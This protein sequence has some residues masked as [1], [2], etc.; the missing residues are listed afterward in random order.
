M[1]L[2]P[3]R[4]AA[5]MLLISATFVAGYNVT[6]RAQSNSR[7]AA[8]GAFQERLT[9]LDQHLQT[10]EQRFGAAA[11]QIESSSRIT[12][13]DM[14]ASA[15]DQ[16]MEAYTEALK[17]ATEDALADAER[18]AKSQGR[19]GNAQKL[20]LLETLVKTHERRT[21]ALRT[22]SEKVYAQVKAGTIVLDRPVLDAL[23]PAER[24][25][26]GNFLTASARKRYPADLVPGSR[27]MLEF[28]RLAQFADSMIQTARSQ[29]SLRGSADWILG[30]IVTPADSAML[31]G[32]AAA[33]SYAWP[34]C[35]ACVGLATGL[36]VQNWSIFRNCWNGSGKPRWTPLWLYRTYCVSAL[37]AIVG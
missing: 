33:C 35:V 32:C 2:R 17:A 25:E 31:I 27:T 22:R 8:T 26:F 6:A 10:A 20:A 36:T 14:E 12:A 11:K 13:R 3:L 28:P 15:V 34:S 21:L 30:S 7:L 18:V 24:E 9:Q 5:W 29:I 19:E 1:N 37:V 16:A 4:Q 23:S